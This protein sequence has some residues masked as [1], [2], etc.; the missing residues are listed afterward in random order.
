MCVCAHQR[1]A[2]PFCALLRTAAFLLT[3]FP[4]LGKTHAVTL[5]EGLQGH[6]A[7][8]GK[9]SVRLFSPVEETLGVSC[10]SDVGTCIIS[11]RVLE[12]GILSIWEQRCLFTFCFKDFNRGRDV[13]G[14]AHWS[15]LTRLLWGGE[16]ERVAADT[17]TPNHLTHTWTHTHASLNGWGNSAGQEGITA[18]KYFVSEL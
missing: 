6:A 2:K 5:M 8:L 18:F 10:C 9:E 14:V 15:H 1:R 3:A 16:G 4:L 13:G 12:G 7:L 17:L 11:H